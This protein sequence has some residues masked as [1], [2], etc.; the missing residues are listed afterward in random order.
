MAGGIVTTAYVLDMGEG[1][2]GLT[3]LGA[4]LNPGDVVSVELPHEPEE[5]PTVV[6]ATVRYCRGSRYGLMFLIEPE[7]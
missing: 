7:G 2:L 1:G 3:A 4:Q 5:E 6:K